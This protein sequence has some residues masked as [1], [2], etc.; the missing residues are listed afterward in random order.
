VETLAD[1]EKSVRAGRTPEQVVGDIAAKVPD[2]QSSPNAH[3]DRLMEAELRGWDSVPMDGRG[4]LTGGTPVRLGGQKGIMFDRVP[5]E[6]AF[7]RWQRGEFLEL[8][9][10]IAKAWRRALSAVD[11]EAR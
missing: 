9:R 7:Y 8:E 3:Q 1:L 4:I 5:E 10:G 6:E 2:M 11:Y